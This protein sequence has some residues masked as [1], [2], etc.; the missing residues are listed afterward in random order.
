MFLNKI[1]KIALQKQQPTIFLF[2]GKPVPNLPSSKELH[3]ESV[4]ACVPEELHS[5]D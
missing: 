3:A 1:K 2:N 4:T 5:K